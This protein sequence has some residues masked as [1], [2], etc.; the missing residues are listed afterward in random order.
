MHNDR[1]LTCTHTTLSYHVSGSDLLEG[2]AGSLI[3]GGFHGATVPGDDP[4]RLATLTDGTWAANGVTV[5][6]NDIAYPGTS[7]QVE[8]TFSTVANITDIIVFSG[9]DNV[10]RGWINCDVEVDTGSGYSTLKSELKTGDYGQTQPGGTTMVGYVRL[11]DDLGANIATAVQ[12]LRI[13]FHAVAH[14][15]TNFFQKF[16]D[17]HPPAPN[18][19]PNMGTVLKEVDVLGTSSVYS[20]E[21]Y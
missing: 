6:A 13:T 20:W 14:N 9:H 12:K 11:Y 10:G 16:D 7:L 2:N 19:Y 1:I 8:W 17:L 4:S 21:L 3:A 5:I 18:N 15:T